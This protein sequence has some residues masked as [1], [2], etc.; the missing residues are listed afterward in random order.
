MA[1]RR[2]IF[3]WCLFDVANSSYT[4][5]IITVAF[6]VIFVQLIVGPDEGTTNLFSRGNFLWSVI[7]SLSA[8][9]GAVLSPL[10]G[11][12]SDVSTKRKAF[13]GFS[14]VICSLGTAMLYFVSPGAIFLASFLIII[15]HSA[16]ALSENFI[17]AFL[18]HLS[19]PETIGKISGWGWG[20][21]YLGGLG[22]IVL[23]GQLVGFEFTMENF[24]NLR[25]VGPLAGLFFLLFSIPTFLFVKEPQT[26]RTSTSLK[27]SIFAA[28]GQLLH[29]FTKLRHYGDLAR[30]LLS[31][32]F[33][34]GGL[35]IVISF[36]ALYGQQVVGISGA[37]FTLFFVSLQITAALGSIFF[38]YLQD[39][40]GALR[41]VNLTLV[42]WILT[43]IAIY[44]LEPIGKILGV[45]NLKI[46]FLIIANFAGLCLGATQASVRAIIGLF[47]PRNQSGEFYGFWGFSGKLAAV[48]GVLVFGSVQ[49]ILD[50]RTALLA[51][52]SFFIIGLLLN[53]TVNQKRAIAHAGE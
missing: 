49:T 34:Q 10:M 37:L 1:R 28:Y 32:F 35:M 24:E 51:C 27:Q 2:E 30:F 8:F 13:L 21:G 46:L 17:S 53:S 48:F 47:S 33:F 18:P 52:V 3:G 19:T 16:F 9:V 39:R 15:T 41:T 6:N 43:I 42:V 26:P 23:C 36:S 5:I 31:F 20:L 38:G 25:L 4:T 22:S 11:A 7:V 50:L 44:F 45:T 12:M 14:A 40:I 29:T